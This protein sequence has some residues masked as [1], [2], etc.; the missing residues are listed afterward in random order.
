MSCKPTSL[1]PQSLPCH[2][3]ALA[4]EGEVKVSETGSQEPRVECRGPTPTPPLTAT[5]NRWARDS[6]PM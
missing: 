5:R 6:L 2:K 3:L 4:P 1:D